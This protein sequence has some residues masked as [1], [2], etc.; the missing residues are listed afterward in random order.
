V[1]VRWHLG[2]DAA[3]HHVLRRFDGC[4]VEQLDGPVA[5]HGQLSLGAASR[6]RA[7]G[8]DDDIASAYRPCNLLDGG[9]LEIACL[10]IH[11]GGA[12]ILGVAWVAD[13]ADD[14]VTALGQ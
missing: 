12:N 11:P 14:L 8:E 1:A 2:A 6:P 10:R 7:G 4:R 3:E 9:A 13:Q 5:I